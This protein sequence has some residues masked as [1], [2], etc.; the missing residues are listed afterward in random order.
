[1]P[2]VLNN[3]MTDEEILVAIVRDYA[4]P[5]N[6]ESYEKDYGEG[7]PV[8]RSPW[9]SRDR[10]EHARRGLKIIEERKKNV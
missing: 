7:R 2:T 10:G 1:M 5:S 6:W 9:S 4:D 3:D 8:M